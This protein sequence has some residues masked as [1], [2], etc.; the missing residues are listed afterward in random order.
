MITPDNAA[1]FPAC[2][3]YGFV[4][5]PNILVKISPREG[6]YERRQ[7]VWS[8]SLSTYSS[9]PIG[10]QHQDDIEAIYNAWMAVGGMSNCFRFTDYMDMQSCGLSSEPAPTD[11]P[12]VATGDSPSGYRLVKDYVFG[13]W[14]LSRYIQRPIGSTIMIANEEGVEQDGSKWTLN[15]A[16]G[17]V[18]PNGGFS[19]TPTFWGGQFHVWVRFDSQLNPTFSNY[20]ILN[21]TVQLKEIRQPLS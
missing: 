4:A 20:K 7:R 6:G 13:P 5:E 12:L 16:N 19:G 8:Q 9:V 2:P 10:D 11:Q 21:V 3:T 14:T 1:V 15:E 18:I 17:V